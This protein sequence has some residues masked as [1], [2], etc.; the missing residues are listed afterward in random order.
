MV[1]GIILDNDVSGIGGI[2]WGNQLKNLNPDDFEDISVLKGAAAT[3]LYGSRALNGVV[4]ITTKSGE[5]RNG[6][7]ISFSQTVG[8][9][10]VYDKPAFQDEYGYGP[11]AGMFSNDVTNGRPDKD[12]HDNQQFAYYENIDGKMYPS[13]QHNNSEENAASWGPKLLGQEYVDYD[14][15]MAKWE[16][17]PNNVKF[18]S[19]CGKCARRKENKRSN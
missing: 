2:D 16:A 6:L 8:T 5:K 7:G 3:A 9:R 14:G 17:Q 18:G 4:L 19:W 1:D 11:S 10:N 15:S 13:L 12:K